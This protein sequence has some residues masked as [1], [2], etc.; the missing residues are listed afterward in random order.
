M[1][2]FKEAI[3][4]RSRL[5]AETPIPGDPTLRKLNDE[6]VQFVQEAKRRCTTDADEVISTVFDAV[7]RDYFQHTVRKQRRR[8]RD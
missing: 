2:S 8:V 1:P 4:A 6:T 3:R 7:A 5:A